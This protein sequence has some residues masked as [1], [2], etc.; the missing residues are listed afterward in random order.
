[1]DGELVFAEV[2]QIIGKTGKYTFLLG[3]II[4]DANLF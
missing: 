4:I 1:M 2:Q 3:Q